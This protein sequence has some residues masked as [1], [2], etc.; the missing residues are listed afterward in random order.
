MKCTECQSE[1]NH[2]HGGRWNCKLGFII[3]NNEHL[4]NKCAS[5]RIGFKT[6]SNIN[7]ERKL[8]QA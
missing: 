4:C 8:Q 3:N 5:K 6:L 1:R 7:N 2:L